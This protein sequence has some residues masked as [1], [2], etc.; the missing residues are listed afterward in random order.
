MRR[1]SK[2]ESLIEIDFLTKEINNW[3]VFVYPTNTLYG[4]WANALDWSAMERIRKIKKRD[5]KPFLIIPPSID[6][7]FDNCEILND[8]VKRIIE[9][10]TPWN[11]SFILKL[12]N[13]KAISTIANNYMETI[14]VRIPDNWFFEIIKKSKC[15]FVSS[16]ANISWQASTWNFREIP[17]EITSKCDYVIE[18][19]SPSG[20]ASTILDLT[21]WEIKV[22]RK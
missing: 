8:E 22:L 10:K 1:L 11:T 9:E 14:W 5:N 20:K 13:K 3:K 15:P 6:W 17:L 12:K 16:S 21:Q 18:C 4:I 7:V 2:E 19:D